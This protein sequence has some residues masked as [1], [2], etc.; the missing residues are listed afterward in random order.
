MCILNC[1]VSINTEASASSASTTSTGLTAQPSPGYYFEASIDDAAA[2][3]AHGGDDTSSLTN[4][5]GNIDCCWL[6]LGVVWL[7]IRWSTCCV[8]MDTPELL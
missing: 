5:E 8:Q 2:G 1:C 7:L 6:A 3:A 4:D